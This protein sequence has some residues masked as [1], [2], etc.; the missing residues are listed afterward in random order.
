MGL[1]ILMPEEETGDPDADRLLAQAMEHNARTVLAVAPEQGPKGW[2]ISESLPIPDLAQAAAALGH[3]DVELDMDGLCR[4]VYLH[5]GL[6]SPH[7]PSFG[8]ALANA[9]FPGL[10]PELDSEPNPSGMAMQPDRWV[11]D[12]RIF[13]PFAGPTGYFKRISY[14]DVLDAQVPD[15][16]LR[17]QVVLVG[18]TAA[19]LGDALATPASQARDRMPGVEMNANIANAILEGRGIRELPRDTHLP[20]SVLVVFFSVLILKS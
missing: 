6:D 12:Q 13:I 19:G 9:A 14:V 1:D 2:L 8:L 3:V 18:A 16:E 20:I 15:S 11:R 7:W 4:S 10:E 5:A 17:D